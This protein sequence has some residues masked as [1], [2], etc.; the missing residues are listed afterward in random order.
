MERKSFFFF[1]AQLSI[2]VLSRW[3]GGWFYTS[4][5]AASLEKGCFAPRNCGTA[6]V[7]LNSSRSKLN[8]FMFANHA[9]YRML[10]KCGFTLGYA[11]FRWF[12]FLSAMVFISMNHLL[13]G[14]PK[15]WK[16]RI[17]TTSSLSLKHRALLSQIVRLFQTFLGSDT[18][19]GLS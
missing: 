16:L 9:T 4:Q 18:F 11:C 6:T 13:C 14:N 5:F 15:R 12:W 19:A 8:I 17:R 1:V 3:F 2:I 7:P 10:D